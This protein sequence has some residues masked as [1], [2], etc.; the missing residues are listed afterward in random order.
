MRAEFELTFALQERMRR[1]QRPSMA[2][3]HHPDWASGLGATMRSVVLAAPWPLVSTGLTLELRCRGMAAR[4]RTI[5]GW[6]GWLL[7][8]AAGTAGWF[9]FRTKQASRVCWRLCQPTVICCFGTNASATQA[10]SCAAMDR[11]PVPPNGV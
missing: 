10:F 11:L 1:K 5:S 8:H 4:C 3:A 7:W 9:G 6:A 2:Q